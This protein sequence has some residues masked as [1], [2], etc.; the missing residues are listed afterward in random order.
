MKWWGLLDCVGEED[1]TG[2]ACYIV[3]RSPCGESSDF[4]FA[5]QPWM[6]RKVKSNW[7]RFSTFTT[8]F[9][10]YFTWGREAIWYNWCMF[11]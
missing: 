10:N 7:A 8:A 9:M 11:S 2:V 1:R 6:G 5:S 3:W 4:K